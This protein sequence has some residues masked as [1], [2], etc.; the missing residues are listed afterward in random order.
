MT[1]TPLDTAHAAMMAAPDDD[2]ARLR[3]YDHLADCELYLMLKEEPR[4][5][6]ITPE[7]FELPEATFALVFDREERL[8]AFA[9]RPVPYVAL[10]GRAIA[11]MIAGQGIGLGLNLEVAPSAILL[12]PAAVDWLATTLS[13]APDQTEERIAEIT[14]PGTLPEALLTALDR[15]LALAAGLA[16][17][18]YLVGTVSD[19]G[20]KGHLL[21]FIDADP[22]AQ[23][24]LAKAAG[25]AL[26]FSGLD[27]GTLDIGFFASQDS[28]AA[29]LARH[30]LRF[31]L[32]D[33][34]TPTAPERPA[35]GSDPNKPPI[36]S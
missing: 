1:E 12:P 20:T 22:D 26:T 16:R 6:R 18:A 25:E 15:K 21:A 3:F 34:K 29:A 2:T 7:L 32:P 33:P 23:P 35:P 5:D 17:S 30:G 27:A 13:E 31:D 36:L 9:E 24:A 11:G 4:E 19:Q 10:S 8:S 28:T 14:R